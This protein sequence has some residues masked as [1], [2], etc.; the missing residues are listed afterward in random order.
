[1]KRFGGI[2]FLCVA[3]VVLLCAAMPAHAGLN[4]GV[5]SDEWVEQQAEAPIKYFYY[6]MKDGN[7]AAEF[8]A[9]E[10]QIKIKINAQG[11]L[12]LVQQNSLKT[13]FKDYAP[14]AVSESTV[15]GEKAAVHDF[16]FTVD[17]GSKLKGR[18]YCFVRGNTGYTALFVG[19]EEFFGA[20]ETDFETVVNGM[21]I[22]DAAPAV[23]TQSPK[24]PTATP[25]PT[26]PTAPMPTPSLNLPVAPTKTPEPTEAP[27]AGPT[28]TPKL[29]SGDLPASPDIA[30]GDA[31][32]GGLPDLPKTTETFWT[33][34]THQYED[35]MARSVVTLPDS[36]ELKEEIL[37]D[38]VIFNGPDASEIRLLFPV[39]GKDVE[40][41]LAEQTEGWSAH[42]SSPI[43]GALAGTITLYSKTETVR[44]VRLIAN[45]A[46]IQ[47]LVEVTLAA[48]DYDKAKSWIQRLFA[49]VKKK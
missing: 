40:N 45:F 47:T 21:T 24:T 7:V 1:M 26:L 12:K 30:S 42:G 39:T 13:G 33:P 4:L 28:A 14:G 29:A 43:T 31:A 48:G 19:L 27:K 9:V 22:G 36:A 11:Y 37:P 38:E 8:R 49:D 17:N 23:P 2:V 5:L 46:D 32:S 44:K 34:G 10:E 6:L 20:L 18:V 15:A 35:P 16:A 25:K 41:R 3:S